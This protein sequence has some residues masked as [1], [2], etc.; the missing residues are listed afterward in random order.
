MPDHTYRERTKEFLYPYVKS[1]QA[2]SPTT[3]A[4]SEAE[5]EAQAR[6][7]LRSVFGSVDPNLGVLEGIGFLDFTPA[8]LGFAV[9]ESIKEAKE[10]QGPLDYIAPAV[11]IGLSA[12]EA[13]PVTKIMTK[14]AIGFLKNLFSK[15][16]SAPVDK[17]KRETIAGMAA[18]PVAGALSNIPVNKIAPVAKKLIP[19]GFSLTGLAAVKRRLDD[20]IEMAVDEGRELDAELIEEMD[21]NEFME[22]I[23]MDEI[24]SQDFEGSLFE[25]IIDEV[26]EKYPDATD[27]EIFNE[28]GNSL[29]N[30][31]DFS[32]EEF[33]DLIPKNKL[34]Y[35]L[36]NF[37]KT[38][39]QKSY[40]MRD[41]DEALKVIKSSS[42]DANPQ[43]LFVKYKFDNPNSTI[44]YEDFKDLR[45]KELG[46]FQGMAEKLG[47]K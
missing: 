37:F 9:D 46:G 27:Q 45:F 33:F 30:V 35:D 20:A 8:G 17:A 43:D 38:R 22:E 3:Q 28:L 40:K 5:K 15:S 25:E 24:D 26:K 16:T 18:V 34:N 42:V 41:Q 6:R 1:Y 21:P 44:T 13:Y 12:V 36:D 47:L 11:G 2:L 32:D 4:L 10:A 29:M 14:P 19:K 31:S 7:T 23:M 39:R